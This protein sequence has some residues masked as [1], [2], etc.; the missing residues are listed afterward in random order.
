MSVWVGRGAKE[1]DR[2]R[3][4]RTSARSRETLSAGDI[5]KESSRRVMSDVSHS[6]T[7]VFVSYVFNV[8]YS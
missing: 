3:G 2:E 8:K 6:R 7:D 4:K 1:S 5:A